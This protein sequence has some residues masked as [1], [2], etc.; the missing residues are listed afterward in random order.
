MNGYGQ[1]FVE[2]V[3]TSKHVNFNGAAFTIQ[4]L[5]LILTVLT[6]T[7]ECSITGVGSV[8]ILELGA[9]LAVITNHELDR[10]AK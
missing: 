8:S 2:H 1:E 7:G 3:C 5:E 4:D 10:V 9:Q 6:R